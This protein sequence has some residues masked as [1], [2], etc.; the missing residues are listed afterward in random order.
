MLRVDVDGVE[1]DAPEVCDCHECGE[2]LAADFDRSYYGLPE[3]WEAWSACGYRAGVV[4]GPCVLRV[5][6]DVLDALRA[7]PE[8]FR[9]APGT[10]FG[11][12]LAL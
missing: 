11:D 4:C 10:A 2:Q 12:W 3:G 8:D 9:W 1:Y 7:A 5:L 6:G